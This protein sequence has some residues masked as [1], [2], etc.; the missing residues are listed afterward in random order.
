MIEK[1]LLALMDPGDEVLYPNPGFPIY[2]SQIEFL[3]GVAKPYGFVPGRGQLPARLRRHQG[4]RSRPARSCSSSTTCTTPPAPRV[5][6]DE[7]DAVAELALKHDLYVLSDEAY[8]DVRYS[9]EPVDR[10]AARHGGA[11]RHPLHLQQEVRHDRLAARRRIGPKELDRV[12]ATLNVNE[13]TLHEPLRAVGRR[14]GAHRRPERARRSSATLQRAPR[15]GRRP[16]RTD[17]RCE[18][19][20][21]RRRPSTCTRTSPARWSAR[22]S[23][24]LRRVAPRGSGADRLSLLHPSALRPRAARRDAQLRAHRLLGHP[25]RA[26]PRRASAS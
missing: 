10:R 14:R 20:L 11:H 16:A 4:G 17:P 21:G 25:R 22:A 7:I 9:G 26:H 1:F 12:I 2:E 3:G 15:R 23:T 6:D 18:L 8:W 5:R 13:E 24:D 19:L